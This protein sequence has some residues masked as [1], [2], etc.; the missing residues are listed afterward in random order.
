MSF[1]KIG[2]CVEVKGNYKCLDSVCKGHIWRII[3]AKVLR[4]KLW[5]VS[6]ALGQLRL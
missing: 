6:K 1:I 4:V 2:K 3:S 5:I